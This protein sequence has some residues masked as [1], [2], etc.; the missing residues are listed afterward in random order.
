MLTLTRSNVCWQ[1]LFQF[2][3]TLVAISLVPDSQL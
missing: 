1:F 2:L 3:E